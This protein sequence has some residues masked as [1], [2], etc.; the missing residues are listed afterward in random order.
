V[1]I[2]SRA[3]PHSLALIMGAAM[4][5]DTGVFFI[6]L[7]IIASRKEPANPEELTLI[8][9]KRSF[10]PRYFIGKKGIYEENE[11]LLRWSE[12]A[13]VFVIRE[14]QEIHLHS[15]RVTI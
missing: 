7:E 12:I 4:F 13:D 9:E 6:I 15:G 10:S 8:A 3:S 1:G 2:G 14:Y 11:L 5:I